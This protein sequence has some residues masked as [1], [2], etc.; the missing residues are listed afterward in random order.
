ASVAGGIPI[1][2]TLIDGF[3]ADRIYK[4]MG[5]LNGTTNYM[6]TRMS[7][8]GLGYD[9]CLQQA[10]ALGYAEA[11][12]TADVEGLDAARKLAILGRL[13]FHMETDLKEVK[14]RGISAVSIEDI[15]Y[16]KSFGYEMKL[17]AI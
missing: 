2:R 1:L 17:L 14:V 7:K 15:H 6:L 16:G 12:P 13:G 3:S 5:I 8:E 11:D 9:E 4:M 10:Q